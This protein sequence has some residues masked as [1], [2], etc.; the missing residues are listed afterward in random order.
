[1]L[2]ILIIK[3]SPFQ[4]SAT[5]TLKAGHHSFEAENSSGQGSPRGQVVKSQSLA[6]SRSPRPSRSPVPTS[7]YKDSLDE[8][9]K[10]DGSS[11]LSA[12]FMPT[13]FQ[14]Y[15]S[16]LNFDPSTGVLLFCC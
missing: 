9:E 8:R 12:N 15:L 10:R 1:M 6:T 11:S 3:L 16:Q 14:A 7:R 5:S 2:L 13:Q 4:E